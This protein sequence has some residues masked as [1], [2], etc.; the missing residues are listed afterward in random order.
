MAVFWVVPFSLVEVNISEGYVASMR[1]S[2]TSKNEDGC[3]LGC[4]AL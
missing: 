4:S 3:L 1:N 2:R